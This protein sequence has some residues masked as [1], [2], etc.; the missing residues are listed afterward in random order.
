VDQFLLKQGFLTALICEAVA[1]SIPIR[2]D[3][4]PASKTAVIFIPVKMEVSGS[5]AAM[6]AGSTLTLPSPLRRERR[7]PSA[8]LFSFPP[9]V[10]SSAA[11]RC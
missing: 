7:L 1:L 2:R 3:S 4:P 8:R 6:F 10:R 5:H 11:G 9:I